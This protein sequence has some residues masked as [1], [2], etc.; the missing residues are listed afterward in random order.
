MEAGDRIDEW[1]NQ[2]VRGVLSEKDRI[3]LLRWLEAAPEHEKQFREMLRI[4]M[5]VSAVGQWKELDDVQQR[6]WDKITLFIEYRKKKLYVWGI[7]IASM[8]IV[9]IGVAFIWQNRSG[10]EMETILVSNVLQVESGSPKAILVTS[11]GEKIA[12]NDG[13]TCQVADVSGIEIIQDSTGSVRFEDRGVVTEEEVC[14]Y[15]SIVVP[16]KGEYQVILSDGTK[17]W[18]NSDSKL[19]FPDRFHKNVREVKLTGE[20][21]F[22]V[23]ADPQ[24]PFYVQVGEAKV[25]VL[26]TAFNVSAYQEDQQVEVALLRGKVGFNLPNNEYVLVPGEIATWDKGDREATLRKGN[27]ESIIDWKTGRF[28]FEDMPLDRLTVKLARWYG[29]QFM[30]EDE[31]VKEFRFSGAV[32]KYRTLD[33]VL[34]MIAKTTKVAFQ[35]KDGKILVRKIE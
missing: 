8:I 35:E 18:I 20:A 23:I 12:L 25:Q 4:K 24:K 32:T 13:K 1:V 5:R 6:T 9:A 26:G 11:A 19:E 30:F 34:G 29:V 3:E 22:E 17:V 21:Y 7:R 16:E 10:S 15:S 31:T 14:R 27:V 2:Y 33:Y 28:N